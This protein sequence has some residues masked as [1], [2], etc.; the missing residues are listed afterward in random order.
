VALMESRVINHSFLDGNKRVAFTAAH[1]VLLVT[2][3]DLEVHPLAA[4][5]FMM[6][7]IA[8]GEFRSQPILERISNHICQGQLRCE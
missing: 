4:Y 5:E 1:T 8:T 6:Q 7:F 3:Y 2:G